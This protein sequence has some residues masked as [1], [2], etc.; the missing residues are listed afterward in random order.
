M[1]DGGL[2][3]FATDTLKM[4]GLQE[5]A[6]SREVSSKCVSA[7]PC[8]RDG[9]VLTPYLANQKHT[10]GYSFMCGY[11]PCGGLTVVPDVGVLR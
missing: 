7:M 8:V 1:L 4:P 11:W 5:V 6:V 9:Y 2:M 10:Q 3:S